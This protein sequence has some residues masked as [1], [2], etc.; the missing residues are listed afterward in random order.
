MEMAKIGVIG[1]A[2]PNPQWLRSTP[3]SGLY[4]GEHYCTSQIETEPISVG[5]AC[6]GRLL[7]RGEGGAEIKNLSTEQ[8]KEYPLI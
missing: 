1:V 5:F 2:V 6:G 3:G 8:I 4:F 7:F